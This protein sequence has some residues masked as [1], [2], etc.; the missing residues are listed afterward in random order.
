MSNRER[1]RRAEQ[2]RR[3]FTIAEWCEA[4]RLSRA[5][6]YRLDAL[7]LAPL[8]HYAGA[9]RLISDEADNAWVRA[10]E[11]EQQESAA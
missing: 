11:A 2:R 8:T 1:Q 7:G 5:M 9:K 10:R 3:S 4:R 6:F